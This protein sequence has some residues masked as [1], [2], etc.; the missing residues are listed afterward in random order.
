MEVASLDHLLVWAVVPAADRD[1]VRIGQEIS[2]RSPLLDRPVPGRVN[3]I[4]ED[5]KGTGNVKIRAVISIPEGQVRP[6]MLVRVMIDP[7]GR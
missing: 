2:V 7:E 6:A 5:A 3:Q 4:T 1:Q